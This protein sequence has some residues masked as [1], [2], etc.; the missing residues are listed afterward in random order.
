MWEKESLHYR[1]TVSIEMITQVFWIHQFLY[2]I[3]VQRGWVEQ[4]QLLH[5]DRNLSSCVKVQNSPDDV[6]GADGPLLNQ[7][8]QQ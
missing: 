2:I 7:I 6:A 8:Q 5:G 1:N 3:S 4:F